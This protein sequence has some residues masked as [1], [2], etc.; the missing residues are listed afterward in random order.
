MITSCAD[1]HDL[2]VVCQVQ[3]YQIVGQQ[4]S[5]PLSVM[6]GYGRTHLTPPPIP[7]GL[8]DKLSQKPFISPSHSSVKVSKT[9]K[10]VLAW[11]KSLYRTQQDSA[12]NFFNWLKPRLFVNS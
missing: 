11:N 8:H 2:S 12:K 10:N 9:P 1:H 4:K 7:T 6:E 5:G 3:A